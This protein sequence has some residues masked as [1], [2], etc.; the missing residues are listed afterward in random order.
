MA[1]SPTTRGR[2]RAFDHD[3]ALEAEL[4]LFWRHGYEATSIS[5]LTKAMGISPPSLY[6]AFGDKR[7]LNIRSPNAFLTF[8]GGGTK[9]QGGRLILRGHRA[10]RIAKYV[11]RGFSP[12]H[13][14]RPNDYRGP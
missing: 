13:R 5:M 12:G 1:A 2:P 8:R 11:P 4:E 10:F 6:A 14:A 7:K 3:A 9:C